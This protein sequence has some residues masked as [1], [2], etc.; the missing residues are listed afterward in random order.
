MPKVSP[1][2]RPLMTPVESQRQSTSAAATT[3]PAASTGWGPPRASAAAIAQQSATG[4]QPS[5]V[6][7]AAGPSVDASNPWLQKLATSRLAGGPDGT[8]VRTTLNNLDRL[9]IPNF[10]GGTAADPNNSRGAMVQLL[11]GGEWTSLPLEGSVPRT[12]KSAYGTAE[13]NV[14]SANAYERLA[15]AGQIPS[16]AIIFQTRHGWSAKSGARGNDMGIVRDGGRVTHNYK[17][18]G[19]IIYGDA[20][21]VVILVPKAALTP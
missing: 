9:G 16:G 5:P 21:E 18:M 17:T 14:I 6:G 10:Q 19:P 8:C 11:R 2:G 20:K 13:A 12:I 1:L 7:D 4:F 3:A 15:K